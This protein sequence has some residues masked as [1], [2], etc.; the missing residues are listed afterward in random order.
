MIMKVSND[1]FKP[2][3]ELNYKLDS[4]L[5]ENKLL[6]KESKKEKDALVKSF[7]F[8][9]DELN[10]TINLLTKQ[11]EKSNE[12]IMK[13]QDE[14][15][16]LKNKNNKNSSNS[17]KPSSTNITTPKKKTGANLYNYRTKTNI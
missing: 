17:S 13:L 15:D 2:F 11:L 7:K 8:E 4:L 16:R 1:F 14:I 6:R 5:E 9:K 10:S 3:E 12:L